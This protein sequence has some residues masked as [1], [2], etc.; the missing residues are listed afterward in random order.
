[1]KKINF[2]SGPSVLP[3]E[4]LRDAAAGLI[5]LPGEGISIAEISHRSNAFTAI[6]EEFIAL[7]RELLA[8]TGEHEV[9][10]LQGGARLQFA[11]IPMNFLSKEKTAGFIDTGYWAHKAI[12][13]AA[14]YGNAR[15]LASSR[16]SGYTSL[17]AY[18]I[19]EKQSLAYVQLTSNNTLYG[20]QFKS[21]P[22]FRCPTIIDM[23]SDLFS[24]RRDLSLVDLAFACAQKNIG[25]SGLSIVIVKK[26]FLA[27]ASENLPPVF[28]YKNLAK[29]HSNYATPPIVNIYMSLLNL[30]WLKGKGGVTEIEKI[31]Q[32]KSSLLYAE[33]E[34]NSL[35]ECRVN[36]EDRSNMNICFFVK[37]QEQESAFLE[38][39]KKNNVVGINGHK[40]TGGFRA[41]LYNAQTI[42]NTQYLVGLMQEFEKEFAI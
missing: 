9:L 14:F 40:V 1:M 18:D 20:T 23:S 30:R 41:S 25:P 39:C 24:I 34:R 12:E 36:P 19:N 27:R 22:V 17:P 11:Q 4:V 2:N 37:D 7:I 13:Y 10:V 3:A 8:L 29:Q 15:I 38:H 6:L 31:N 35:F 28:S 42:E 32:V 21:L 26:D 33:I 16:D 5:G